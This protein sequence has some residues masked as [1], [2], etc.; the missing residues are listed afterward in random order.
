MGW[1]SYGFFSKLP[2]FFLINSK[3]YE[4]CD[5]RDC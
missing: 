3:K 5:S 2:M 4:M 1:Q